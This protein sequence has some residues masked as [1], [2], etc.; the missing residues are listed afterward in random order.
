M[1]TSGTKS[2]GASRMHS[3]TQ[4]PGNGQKIDSVTLP[5]P[6]ERL[7]HSLP[8]SSHWLRKPP[9]CSM[10]FKADRGEVEDPAVADF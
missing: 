1:N 3:K 5:L 9:T 10:T 2:P 7:A 8:N 6:Q 4:E